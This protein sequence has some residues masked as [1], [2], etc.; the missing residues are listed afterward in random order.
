MSRMRHRDLGTHLELS[1]GWLGRYADSRLMP[2][3]KLDQ[4]RKRQRRLARVFFYAA[5]LSGCIGGFI[6]GFAVLMGA[7]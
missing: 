6:Y 3:W 1:Q 4:A 5:L 7:Q 2:R